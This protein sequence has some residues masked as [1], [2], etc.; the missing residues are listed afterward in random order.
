MLNIQQ[1]QGQGAAQNIGD[2]VESAHL[3]EMYFLEGH[4]MDGGFCL[5]QPG[6]GPNSPVSRQVRQP[7]PINQVKDIGKMPGR[8]IGGSFH[9][10]MQGPHTTVLHFIHRHRHRQAKA[11]QHGPHCVEGRPRI[12]QRCQQHVT[13]NAAETVQMRR[14]HSSL[15][16]SR[17][18]TIPNQPAA[19]TLGCWLKNFNGP[20]GT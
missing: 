15:R 19:H 6:E 13:G 16:L 8:L 12:D 1:A 9:Q 20:G 10:Q 3:M 5:T 2:A 14:C 17:S 11:G 18:T 4:L 7:S